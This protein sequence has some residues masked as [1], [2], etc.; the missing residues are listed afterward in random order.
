MRAPVLFVPIFAA[1]E[2]EPFRRMTE[3]WAHVESF[4]GPGAGARSGEHP[5]TPPG[6]AASAAARLDELGWERCVVVCDSHGQAA[7]IELAVRDP[8]VA[9]IAVSHAAMHYT[10]TGERPTLN[11]SIYEAAS[12]LLDTDQR[13][14]ARALTQ[15]TQG[16]FDDDWVDAY[17]AAVPRDAARYRLDE[18]TDGL[19]LVARLVEEDVPVLLAGHND[20]MMWTPEAI[21]DAAAALPR[22]PL[23][24]CDTAPL[25]NPGFVEAVREFCAEVLG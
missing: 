15:L 21:E 12:R 9:G 17:S 19:E 5:G 1:F 6:M 11:A 8:R 10:L 24:M 14:F 7:G 25:A 22:A 23:V 13:S 4:D 18:L 16:A 20:C 3:G 2:A